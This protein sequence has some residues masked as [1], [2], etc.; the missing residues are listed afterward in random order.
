MK[1]STQHQFSMIPDVKLQRSSF[2]RSHG[3]KTTFNAGWLIPIFVDEALPGDT[4]NLNMTSLA[5]LATPLKPI[6]DNVYL[7]TFFFAVP[8]RLLWSK[9]EKF[10]GAQ[11][12]PGDSTD[13]AIPQ[14]VSPVG[15]WPELGVEDYFGLPT[16]IAGLS[17]SA[18]F[19][20]AYVRIYNEWFRDENLIGDYA[21]LT[22]DGP[23]PY[24]YDLKRRAKR[25]DY[26][27]SCLPWPQKGSAVS[28]PLSGSA[29]V[30]SDGTL[31]FVT[32][33]VDNRTLYSAAGLNTVDVN[34]AYANTGGLIWGAT[35]DITKT[36]LYTDLTT[37]TATTINALRQAFQLQ[38]LLE[39]DARGGTRYIEI[40]K[41]HF[42][43]TSPDFRLQRPEYLGGGSSHINVTP[44]PQT[45]VAA[46]TP[47][48]NLAAFGQ[49][50]LRSGFT[51]SFTEHS[52]IIGLVN[53]RAD[54]TYQQGVN[55]MFNRHT[56][57]DFYWP[58]F[59]NL[60]EQAVINQ[61][62]YAQ[63]TGA[64]SNVF[65]YQ[66]RYAEYRYKPS[67]VSGK[68]R[69]NATGTL[70]LWHLAQT[71]VTGPTLGQ[72]FIEENPPM[73]RVMAVPTEPQI[74]MDSYFDLNCV[75]PM[76]V[77]SVPG[78]IDHF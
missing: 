17:V 40:I 53:V 60:G 32:N 61:E 77:Y 76:P 30:N 35:G 63:G 7:D 49:G 71:F 11:D 57:Y 44:V 33:G 74:I 22:G 28:L 29:K 3:H 59:A 8:N 26:F 68:F 31:P 41:S 51:K 62:I 78:L 69:S 42:G 47:Q 67:I 4:F 2:N 16:K 5:R 27:T 23:D 46:G 6:M 64:D 73:S 13:F 56:R 39:R 24:N 66:E 75:R 52:I 37:A 21:M 38:K 72:T 20:R 36:G 55:K 34:V 70:D 65:G 48:A 12:N 9:W 1:A 50:S 58:A 14:T 18:L 19:G 15:G 45:S 25:A 54:V 43:V 10:N